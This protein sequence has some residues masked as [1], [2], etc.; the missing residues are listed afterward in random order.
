L[1]GV[2]PDWKGF[3]A[4]E[5]LNRVPL[6]TYPWERQRYWVD[7]PK[8]GEVSSAPRGGR[9][10]S[11]AEWMY[12]PSWSR[13]P[14]PRPAFG[15][16]PVLVFADDS[17]LSMET[18]DALRDHGRTPR[19]VRMGDAFGQTAEGWTV[20][21]ASREDHIKLV[22]A[23]GEGDGVPSTILH[24]WPVAE[25]PSRGTVGVLVLADAL[26]RV[27]AE[28]ALVAV[29]AGAAEVGGDETVDAAKAALLGAAAVLR[30]ETPTVAVRVVDVALPSADAEARALGARVAAEALAGDGREVALRGR[31]R[32]TRS[33][34][35]IQPAP[36]AAPVLR[37]GGVYLFIGGLRGRNERLAEHLVRRYGARIV[38]VDPTLPH[39]GGWDPVVKARLA[40]DP[41]R[42]QIERIRALEAEGAEILT[43]QVQPAEP[44]QMRD[45]FRQIESRFGA[46][47]GVVVS[48]LA[49]EEHNR[50]SI[51]EVRVGPYERWMAHLL[52]ELRGVHAVL[53]ERA[54]DFVVVES[55]LTAELGGVGLIGMAATDAV[56]NAFAASD[57]AGG[58]QPWTA[59]AW[60]RW[61]GEDEAREGYGMS[62]DEAAAAFEHLLTHAGEPLVLL[63]TGDLEHR[64]TARADAQAGPAMGTYARPELATEYHAPSTDVEEVVAAMWEELLGISPIGVH[65]DFFALGGHSLLATQIIVRCR[66]SFGLELQLK[67][68]FEAPTIARFSVLVED[69]IIADM[70]SLTD[71]EAMEL[72]GA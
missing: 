20:R 58:A 72:A 69:A 60:D 7:A 40:E 67:A 28:T 45:A 43:I 42:R 38:L 44:E 22:D 62:E 56:V 47:H 11:P 1:A 46:L 49:H 34:R 30:V 71:E 66:E 50:E 21:P 61:F 4:G 29:T 10:A 59:A 26:N 64:I 41:L 31:H 12:V 33:Y 2:T 25:A 48:A 27:H 51:S 23:L 63:S 53:A 68:I 35:P 52:A 37:E 32:W 19:V 24:L 13:M 65:D 57:T 8:P 6:P 54:L 9:K 3:H 36:T 18:V 55:S 14:A 16:G 17:P 70:E 15:E 39:R 5:R